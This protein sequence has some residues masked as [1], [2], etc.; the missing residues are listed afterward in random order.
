MQT[1]GQT[2]RQADRQADSQ[3]ASQSDRQTDRDATTETEQER[4]GCTFGDLKSSSAFSQMDHKHPTGKDVPLIAM[5]LHLPV[6][7]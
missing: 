5:S 1:D 6:R 4:K 2:D 7:M 3:P